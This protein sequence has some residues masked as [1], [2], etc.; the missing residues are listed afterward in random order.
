MTENN[1][2][3]S[4]FFKYM[5]NPRAF[6]LKKW[7]HDLLGESYAPHDTAIERVATALT[8]DRDVEDFGKLMTQVFEKGYRK[9]VEDYRKEA[10]RLGLTVTV[11]SPGVTR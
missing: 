1:A 11:V 3:N 7:F 6:T 4:N 8:T 2:Q 5:M 10:E 9:A